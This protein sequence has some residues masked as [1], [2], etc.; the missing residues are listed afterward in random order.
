[1]TWPGRDH[2]RRPIRVL[3]LYPTVRL[4]GAEQS[5]VLMARNGEAAGLDVSVAVLFPRSGPSV[6]PELEALGITPHIVGPGNGAR[7]VRDWTGTVRRL[8][9][10]C[11]L[12]R[13][14]VVDSCMPNA[15]LVGRFACAGRLPRHVVHLIAT[16]YRERLRSETA[17]RSRAAARLYSATRWLT[18]GYV[19]NSAAVAQDAR[20]GLR[21]P[22]KRMAVIPRGVDLEGFSPQP[23]PPA[24]GGLR[25]LSVGRLTAQKDLETAVRAVAL[26]REGDVDVSLTIAGQGPRA[27]RLTALASR[28]G[29]DGAVRL[30][31]PTR[32]VAALHRDHDAFVFPSVY[33]GLGNSL[34]EAMASARPAIVS[35][36]A[37]NREAA[38]GSALRF[39]PG[40][41]AAMAA[42][43]RRFAAMAPAERAAMGSR[44]RRRAEELYDIRAVV[45]RLA[46]YYRTLLE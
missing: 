32:A 14:D 33:E 44:A 34:L 2:G 40:D 46:A 8:A 6:V 4:G 31:G 1:M 16:G 18:D 28:L 30:I 7:R 12:L 19:A 9:R 25:L 26:A 37:P 21:I 20:L 43:I 41:G 36:I 42:A 15:D 23:P 3:Y 29:L 22:E 10:L 45:G 27:E 38:G 39:P 17:G 11:R 13:I 5:L 35:D 24:A